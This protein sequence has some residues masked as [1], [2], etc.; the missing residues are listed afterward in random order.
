MKEKK[1]RDLSHI[2]R[3][4]T[5]SFEYW[6]ANLINAS[7]RN[8]KNR[9]PPTIKKRERSKSSHWI[10]KRKINKHPN[11]KSASVDTIHL[12]YTSQYRWPGCLTGH[13]RLL[14]FQTWMV[15]IFGFGYLL[16]GNDL[17]NID[18][19]FKPSTDTHL[20]L[21]RSHAREIRNL[22]YESDLLKCMYSHE[23]TY[24]HTDT[25]MIWNIAKRRQ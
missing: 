16:M 7:S 6:T 12:I 20:I 13:Q 10:S 23:Y 3:F 21:Q 19:I 2:F 25:Y 15:A 8:V 5:G 4:K 24:L 1:P 18:A 22:T 14:V 11:G 9:N 17:G